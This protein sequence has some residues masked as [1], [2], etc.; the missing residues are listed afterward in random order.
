M[1][2]GQQNTD[3]CKCYLSKQEIL[4]L[5]VQILNMDTFLMDH[6]VNFGVELYRVL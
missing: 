3:Y 5:L 1:H 6:I 2:E 4:T